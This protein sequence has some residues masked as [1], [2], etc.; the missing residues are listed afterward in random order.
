MDG[1]VGTV[2]SNKYRIDTFIKEEQLGKVYEATR[3]GDGVKVDLKVLHPHLADNQEVLARFG[4]EMLATASL[5]H[6][7]TVQMLDFEDDRIFHYL[8]LEHVVGRSIREVLDAEGP[9]TVARAAHV[10]AQIASALGA[11]GAQQITHRNLSSQS[12]LLAEGQGGWDL[13]KIRDFGLSKLQDP[14]S[15]EQVTVAGMRVGSP[16]YMPPE[17]IT[18]SRVDPRGDLY[19]LGVLLFEMLTGEPVF[20]TKRRGDLLEMHV[21]ET[22]RRPS[23]LNRKVPKWLDELVLHLLAKVPEQRPNSGWEVVP[24]LEQ[25]VGHA[26]GAPAPK[27]APAAQAPAATA[28][29]PAKRSGGGGAAMVGVFAVVGLGVVGLGLLA[30]AA[31]WFSGAL[32]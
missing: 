9:F 14:G 25:G 21:A 6:P 3:L 26:L 24:V 20:A 17:Y 5:E 18:D 12:I 23:K 7:N 30:L 8:V 27:H 31:V 28:A 11:A 2:L 22:P 4:R 16:T 15:D 19:A 10:A 32:G 13:V 29:A 1:V